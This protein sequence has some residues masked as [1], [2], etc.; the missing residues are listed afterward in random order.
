MRK[1]QP[2]DTKPPMNSDLISPHFGTLPE[3]FRLTAST[4]RKLPSPYIIHKG[5]PPLSPLG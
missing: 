5:A 1:N 2:A 3:N 4:G